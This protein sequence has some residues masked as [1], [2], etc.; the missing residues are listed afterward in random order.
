MEATAALVASPTLPTMPT[1]PRWRTWPAALTLLVLSPLVAEVTSGSTPPLLAI[2][3]FALIFLPTL[4]GISIL[5]VHEIMARR[6]LGWGNAL[7]LG[8]AFGVFQEAL[9]VQT[10]FNYISPASPSH[11]DALYGVPWGT[12]VDWALHLT[13]YHAVVSITV[14]LMLIALFFPRHA[15]LPWLGPKRIVLLTAWMLLLCGALAV[16]VAFTQFA[17]DGYHGPP[18]I[19]YLSS[20]ALTALLILLGVVARFPTPRP[21]LTRRAPR[22]WTAR[23]M[24]CGCM[25]LFFLLSIVLPATKMPVAIEIGLLALVFAWALSR[26]RSWSAR[27]GWNERHVL[28]VAI[29]VIMYFVFIWGPFIEF[30]LRLPLR[31]GMTVVNLLLFAAL[32]LFDQRLKRRLVRL[33][34]VEVG[35]HVDAAPPREH[36][37]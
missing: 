10:W 2:Q 28:S 14:P 7:L 36:S 12:K 1:R 3:P 17:K 30:G 8:A 5:L 37:A 26:V 23:L 22:L 13:L 25:V 6:R 29:G 21:N 32:L 4:Y 15:P 31:T 24:C 9:I 20:I 16:N 19:P 11:S 34:H 35:A 27:A 18:P 33:A